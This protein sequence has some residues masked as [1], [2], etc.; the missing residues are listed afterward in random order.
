MLKIW[1]VYKVVDWISFN[2]A[3]FTDQKIIADRLFPHFNVSITMDDESKIR[4]SDRRNRYNL[5]IRQWS[6]PHWIGTQII[7][8]GKNAAYF[9][10]LVKTQ[11]YSNRIFEFDQKT[12]SLG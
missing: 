1:Q 3:G 6:K 2:I 4:F 5:S 8:S 12:I 11:K 7:F 10:N 9:Y